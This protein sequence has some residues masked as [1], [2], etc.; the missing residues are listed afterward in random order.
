[1]KHFRVLLLF[2]FIAC[3]Q[4]QQQ[5]P[6]QQQQQQ[7]QE[8]M[9]TAMPGAAGLNLQAL[10]EVVRTSTSATDIEQKVNAPSGINNLDLDGDGNVDYVF[11]TEYNA[12][13]TRGFSFTVDNRGE[14][15]ELATIQVTNTGQTANVV[16]AGNQTV[17][18]TDS[19]YSANYMLTD[20]LI[21]NYMYRPHTYYVSP[22]HYGYYPGYYHSYRLRSYDDYNT[23]VTNV[24]HT[25][26]IKK[27]VVNNYKSASPN[28]K[29]ATSSY[30]KRAQPVVTSR[31]SAYQQ[32]AMTPKTKAYNP[33]TRQAAKPYI[34]PKASRSSGYTSRRK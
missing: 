23:H 33:P 8:V 3:N 28:R 32:R 5:Q 6:V 19:Y 4:P 15:Q 27:T 20:F 22:Y 1:M 17:Y 26:V 2:V 29:Y 31:R 11:V 14:K 10:G 16:I 25:T 18:G 21:W 12:G 30:A 9:T 34:P 13:N 7:P 24:T